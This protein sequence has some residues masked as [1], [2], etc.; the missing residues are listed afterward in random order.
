[1]VSTSLQIFTS[2]QRLTSPSIGQTKDVDKEAGVS[3]G[4]QGY[5]RSYD[6]EDRLAGYGNTVAPLSVVYPRQQQIGRQ[7]PIAMLGRGIGARDNQRKM[8]K[9]DKE[10][11]K[12]KK[13]KDRDAVEGGVK[14]VSLSKTV[15][16]PLSKIDSS[17]SSW[18]GRRLLTALHTGNRR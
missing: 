1:M 11:Q 14:W 2:E 3:A 18:S 7:D 9:A 5:N 15:R 6:P 16:I 13:S 17:R 8:K 12:G 4:S 10:Q